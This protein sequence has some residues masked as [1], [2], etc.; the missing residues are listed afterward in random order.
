MRSSNNADHKRPRKDQG[1]Q[2]KGVIQRDNEKVQ[3]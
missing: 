1:D 2:V 3:Y